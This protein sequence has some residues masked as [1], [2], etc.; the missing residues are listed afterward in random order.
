MIA[1][2]L[3]GQSS[4]SDVF[5]VARPK[6]SGRGSASVRFDLLILIGLV[7]GVVGPNCSLNSPLN[8]PVLVNAP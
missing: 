6:F 8:M 1:D 3:P 2:P 4:S 5:G 7:F